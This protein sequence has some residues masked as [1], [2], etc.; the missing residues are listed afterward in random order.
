[1]MVPMD[2]A[3]PPS[4]A[5][6]GSLL[7]ELRAP[8]TW[9]T[10][11]YLL[12]ALP[13]GLFASALLAGGVIGGVLTLPLLVGAAVLLGCLWLV[14]AIGE[15]HRVLAGLLGVYFARPLPP[16]SGGLLTWLRTTLA[17]PVTYRTLL[18]VL[19]Q[20]P[21]A[22][23][24]WVALGT[25]LSVM[26]LSLASPL[27][28]L[29]PEAWPV[30]WGERT[31]TPSVEAVL[32]LLLLGLGSVIVLGGVIDLFGRLWTRLSV[33]LLA[34]DPGAE[35]ARREVVALRRAAGR[36]ALGDDLHATL[37]DLTAQARAASTADAVILLAPDGTLLAGSGPWPD[38]QAGMPE[39]LPGPGAADVRRTPDGT[40]LA[41][42]PV[43]LPVS[44]GG[45]DGGVLRARY[46][47]GVRPSSD[48][49]AFLLSISD[50][51]GTALHAAHLIERAGARAGEL[52]RARLARELHDSVAQALYGITLGAKTARAT[53]DS[54]PARTR[55][56]LEYTIR[57]AEG[58][59]S[60]MKALL[61]SLRPDALEE[62]GLVAALRQHAH[63]LETRHGL[64][65]HADLRA[66]PPLAPDAQAAAYRVA[67]EAMHNV[68][69]HARAGQVWLDVQVVAL[70]AGGEHV[71]LSV[72]DDGRGF[73]PGG[74]VA[75]TLGQRGMRE[76]AAG[77]GGT[78]DVRSAPGQGTTVTLSVPVA[79]P[80]GG[81]A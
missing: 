80:A 28:L 73:D 41:T 68:V 51:A 35:A 77:V 50:H 9:R 79:R 27:W 21:L 22:L 7:T 58:G 31:V 67:Q 72:R 54:D 29:N 53:L 44:A 16:V 11:I 78:L 6:P 17:D 42:L 5:R 62:G 59:V 20:P 14:G 25:L 66:E 19:V 40:L 26:V 3:A 49:L 55:Q 60:E 36:V 43:T 30:V 46:A 64:N 39:R 23:L 56:S 48:E 37:L 70:P 38:V 13:A 69:K 63:A 81:S 52:E 15:L 33:A 47:P 61:F 10:A 32:G 8:R 4:P 18:F 75:G 12:L 71:V 65:V 57:L 2:T 76:R 24:C 34:R 74:P 1:M 45:P